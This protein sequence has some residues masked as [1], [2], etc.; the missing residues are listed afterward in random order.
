VRYVGEPIA[1]VI[2]KDEQTAAEA[3]DLI[4]V[5]YRKLPTIDSPEEA[6]E[7]PEVACIS[8]RNRAI[9]TVVRLMSSRC[10]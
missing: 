10:G 5:Q 2:A 7:H 8:T 3:V 6:L 9:S 1:A 4:E